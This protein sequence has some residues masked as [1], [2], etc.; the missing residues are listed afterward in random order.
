MCVR[1]HTTYHLP[2]V[3]ILCNK[4]MTSMW[5]FVITIKAFCVYLFPYP[6]IRLIVIMKVPTWIALAYFHLFSFAINIITVYPLLN[7]CVINIIK[8]LKEIMFNAMYNKK[9]LQLCYLLHI[10]I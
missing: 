7:T 1:M 10:T 3:C 4:T 8:C 2:T 5:C 6:T 9:V